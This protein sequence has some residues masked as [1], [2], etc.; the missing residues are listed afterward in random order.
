MKSQILTIVAGLFVALAVQAAAG[1]TA[2]AT[3]RPERP[4]RHAPFSPDRHRRD[5]HG[6][7]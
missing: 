5:R 3:A 2:M 4:P 7:L 6:R 1:A